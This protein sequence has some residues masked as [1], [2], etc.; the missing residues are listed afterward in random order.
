MDDLAALGDAE[1]IA[2]VCAGETAA[3]AVV[4]RRY[5]SLAIRTA[6]LLGAGADAEDVAQEAFVKAYRALGRFRPGSAFRPWLLT[7]VTHEA[8]NL[9][10]SDRRRTDRELRPGIDVAPAGPEELAESGERRALTRQALAE[11]PAAQREVLVCRF[12]LELDERETAQVLGV[13]SGTVKSRT[14]RGLRRMRSM[15]ADAFPAEEVGRGR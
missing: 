8:R 9:H 10:R 6:A 12:L 2:R 3:Y 14:W 7:I 4:V 13:A 15:L 5:S 1:L 11:L